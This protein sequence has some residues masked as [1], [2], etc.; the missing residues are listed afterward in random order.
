MPAQ[1]SHRPWPLK[2]IVL[3]ILLVVVPYTFLRWHYRK[4]GPAFAPYHD[5]K[6]RANTLRLLSAGFQRITLTAER[7]ADS[8]RA[9]AAAPL[10]AVP[11]GLPA[12]LASTL[13]DQPMLPSDILSVSAPPSANAMFAYSVELRCT[14]PDLKQQ[15]AGGHLYVHGEEIFIVPLYEQIAGKLLA[16]TTQ[17]VV[18]LTAPAG[19]LKPGHYRVTLVGARSSKAWSL[20]VR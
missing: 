6:D 11:G 7:P 16:R 13:V 10:S 9:G 19:S 20:E 17:D 14:H 1:R 12:A 4:P 2:S 3:V 5:M 8:Q 15:L 18:R